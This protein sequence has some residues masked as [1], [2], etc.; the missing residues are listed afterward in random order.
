MFG[1]VTGVGGT[2]GV[3]DVVHHAG[4]VGVQCGD[5]TSACAFH[6][7][8]INRPQVQPMV[9]NVPKPAWGWVGVSAG[10]WR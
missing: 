10:D 2:M 7:G 4:E 3:E 8:A 1:M 6:M 5:L 9:E